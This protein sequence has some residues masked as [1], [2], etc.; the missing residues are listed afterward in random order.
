MI[1]SCKRDDFCEPGRRLP[2]R[3]QLFLLSAILAVLA[4][5]CATHNGRGAPEFTSQYLDV[6]NGGLATLPQEGLSLMLQLKNK[7]E[8]PL[9]VSVDF[10]PPEREDRCEQVARLDPGKSQMF[11]CAQETITP[12]EDYIVYVA[13][14]ADEDMTDMIETPHTKF[15]FSEADV[16][17]FE[18][19]MR[20]MESE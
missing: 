1:D 10:A 3:L 6:Q 12:E 13:V 5:S 2:I 7:S 11:S 4:S 19:V 9:W 20:S 18:E 15:R 8:H 17:V 14:F 16:A